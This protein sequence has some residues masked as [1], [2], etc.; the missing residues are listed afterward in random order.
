MVF[1]KPGNTTNPTTTSSPGGSPGAKNA[2]G[3]VRMAQAAKSALEALGAAAEQQADRVR[4]AA[5]DMRRDIEDS[6]DALR[7]ALG[8]LEEYIQ[9]GTGPFKEEIELQIRLLRTG[10]ERLDE[11]LAKVGDWKVV[12]ENGVQSIRQLLDRAGGDVR[13]FTDDI[14]KLADQIRDGSKS[15][16]DGLDYLR[17]AGGALTAQFVEMV[18]AFQNGK[19]NLDAVRR[20]LEQLALVAGPNSPLSD[21]ARTITNA[22]GNGINQGHT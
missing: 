9:R 20:A 15:V 2:N 10:G 22:L 1:I 21:A 11:F 8:S 19:V 13:G 14:Q 4:K 6:H 5:S 12:T 7:R 17:E 18:Q 16:A 3:I